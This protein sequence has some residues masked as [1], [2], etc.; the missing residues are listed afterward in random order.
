MNALFGLEKSKSGP[1]LYVLLMFTTIIHSFCGGFW[2][3]LRRSQH[4]DV[5][6]SLRIVA[7]RACLWTIVKNNVRDTHFIRAN[8]RTANSMND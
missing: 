7:G 8:D 1:T 6:P 4:P 3:R 2:A 5:F